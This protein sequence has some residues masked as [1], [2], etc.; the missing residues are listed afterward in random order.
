MAPFLA[1]C[2]NTLSAAGQSFELNH[3]LT[4][5]REIHITAEEKEGG[6]LN[7]AFANKNHFGV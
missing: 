6:S 3:W 2:R 4:H 1:S 5:G 7:S